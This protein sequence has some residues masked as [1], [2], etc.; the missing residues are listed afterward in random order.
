[1]SALTK[2][3]IHEQVKARYSQV[4]TDFEPTQAA[5]DPFA[6]AAACCAPG[7]AVNLAGCTPDY[8][9]D[10]DGLPADVT[11]LSLGCGDPITL[12]ELTP[13]Q[14]VLDLGSGAG[15]DVFLAA[16]QVGPGGHVIGVDM[17]EAMLAKAERN[18]AKVGLT[19]VEFRQGQIEALP[20]DADSVDVIIF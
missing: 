17:T 15:I 8:A 18:K 9:V 12:A 14:T 20:I 3:T 16:R 5:V 4:V 13:G 19:N 6:A 11:G 7:D 10:L 1:M 2:E